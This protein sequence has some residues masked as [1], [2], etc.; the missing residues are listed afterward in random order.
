MERDSTAQ[1]PGGT[2]KRKRAAAALQAAGQKKKILTHDTG[3]AGPAAKPAALEKKRHRDPLP[4]HWRALPV[5][6]VAPADQ[7]AAAAA[8]A[9]FKRWKLDTEVSPTL[10]KDP[11]RVGGCFCMV[12]YG[13]VWQAG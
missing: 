8:A 10:P 13:M 9:V 1:L 3:L 11:V 4:P 12:R 5:G 7:A 2:D 6:V